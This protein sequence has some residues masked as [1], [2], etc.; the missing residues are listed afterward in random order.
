MQGLPDTLRAMTKGA[1]L[2]RSLQEA[3]W[4]PLA[5]FVGF[6]VVSMVVDT[7]GEYADLDMPAHFAGGFAI[8][9]FYRVCAKNAEDRVGPIPRI[10]QY[11]LAAG[12]AAF[13]AVG[14]ELYEYFSD[15]FFATDMVMG[16]TD[17]LSDLTF[18]LL[19]A[20]CYAVIGAMSRVGS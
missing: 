13:T 3:A 5:V 7:K 10:I 16:L 19:G 6:K 14:W 9:Y 2:T 8:A 11:I 4:A 1:W 20:I 12:L 18:G 15:R 17:T